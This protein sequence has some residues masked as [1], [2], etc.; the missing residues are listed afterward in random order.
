MSRNNLFEELK[1]RNVYKVAVAYLVVSWL[2]IQAASILLPTF[3]APASAMKI[4]VALLAIGFP[5][6][7][8]FSWAFEITPEGI[9]RESEV[10]P[11]QSIASHTGRRLVGLT[12]VLA[13]IAA[14]LFA[15]QMLRSH[16]AVGEAASFPPK[17]DGKLTAS[18]T[19]ATAAIPDKSIA[20]LPFDN[21]SDEK[22]NAYFAEG[23]QDEILTR[24]AK[25][26]ALK[27]ISRSS[28][29][30][31]QSKPGNL[32][33]IAQ[34][35]GVANILEGSVQKA[36][37]AVH[38]NVQLI[39]AMTDDHLWAES[40]D[41]TL[42]NI[43]GVEGEI[44]QA[45][46]EALKAKL[47]GAEEKILAQKP[48][49]NP[50]AYEAYLRGTSQSSTMTN[51]AQKAAVLSFEEAVRLDPHFALAWAALS[52][53]NSSAFFQETTAAH[54]DGAEK[55]LKEAMR[56]QPDLAET[57]LARA[58]FQYWVVRDY[59]GA[60]EMMQ[61]LRASWPNNAEVLH[62]MS[63]ISARLGRWSDSLDYL[64]QSVALNPKE[65][66]TRNQ[67]IA[68]GLAMREFPRAL[69]MIDNALQIWPNDTNLLGKKA[70][71]LQARGQLDEA[72]AILSKLS[73]DGPEL[74]SSGNAL[75]YQSRVRRDPSVALKVFDAHARGPEGNDPQFLLAWAILQK[76]VGQ[77][78]EAQ[79]TFT[80]SRDILEQQLKEQ[81]N[82]ANVMGPLI[83]ALSALG[84]R[85]DTLKMLARYDV[86]TTGDA[87]SVGTGHDLRARALVRLGDKDGAIASLEQLLAA[88]SDPI[89]A[90]PVTPAT[91]RLD[92]DFDS[93]H[94]DPRFQKLCQEKAN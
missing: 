67:G 27:V 77:A 23:I 60:L 53:A 65:L 47:T 11:D 92:P 79:T 32:R 83:F 66:V 13:I 70:Y 87:R 89:Y 43:F 91:L 68:I 56:L 29:K 17:Q 10:T 58:Y 52:Q 40:Y 25:I 9:K 5:I 62:A 46:A 37:S 94:G 19:S 85:D 63:L 71:V 28:T 49:T 16:A 93:L 61:K 35:L 3:D 73:F 82:N 15:Y 69:A 90:V 55:A 8:G 57:Q 7:L 80:R 59:P 48:T 6:A 75:W 78:A 38:V 34:Q 72:Q 54:R 1:R 39:K 18:P 21:L 74:D 2:L 33:E 45:V 14:A 76:Q 64:D 84:Q 88:P 44:A 41:R 20:V 36:G 26:G 12:I 4:L 81:P 86:V 24:L 22:A 31:Y 50:E 51:D 42:E 30:Q